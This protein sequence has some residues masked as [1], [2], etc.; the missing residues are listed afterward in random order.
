MSDKGLADIYE[1]GKVYFEKLAYC[2]EVVITESKEGIDKNFVSAVVK[3]CEIYIPLGDLIDIE[4]EIQRLQGE[5]ERLEGEIERVNQKLANESFVK[6]GSGKS[7]KC[8]KRKKGQ[9]WKWCTKAYWKES[10]HWRNDRYD[11]AKTSGSYKGLRFFKR[12]RQK[13]RLQV[14]R[15]CKKRPD[16]K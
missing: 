7:R 6:K 10:V 4:K 5:K 1:C 11:K 14:T 13:G 15:L 9:V 16:K 8:G 12:I 3:G 2:S